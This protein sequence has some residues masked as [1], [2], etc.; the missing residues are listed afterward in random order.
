MNYY[1]EWQRSERKERK[2]IQ[3]EDKQEPIPIYGGKKMKITK[4]MENEGEEGTMENGNGQR[5]RKRT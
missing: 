5:K 1:R 4:G 3:K 2:W